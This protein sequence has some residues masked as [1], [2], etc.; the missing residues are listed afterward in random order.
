MNL[1]RRRPVLYASNQVRTVMDRVGD[2]RKLDDAAC[3]ASRC[4]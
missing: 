2:E 1:R 3:A 4:C